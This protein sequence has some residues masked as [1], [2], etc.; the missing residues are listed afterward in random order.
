MEKHFDETL[1]REVICKQRAKGFF[2][3]C[4]HNVVGKVKEDGSKISFQEAK[5]LYAMAGIE[6][7][8]E[9][10]YRDLSKGWEV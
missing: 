8:I 9:G 4:Y 7:V 5:G 1:M 2:V 6:V 3:D 10:S